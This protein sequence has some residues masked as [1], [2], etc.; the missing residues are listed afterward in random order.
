MSLDIIIVLLIVIALLL[1]DV[2]ASVKKIAKH[3]GAEK[4]SLL[5]DIEIRK[6]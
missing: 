5:E 3:L 1:W 4:K 6:E 2:Q